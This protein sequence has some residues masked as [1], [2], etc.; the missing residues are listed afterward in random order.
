MLTTLLLS[1]NVSV[2]F[3]AMFWPSLSYNQIFFNQPIRKSG[4]LR[5]GD[6]LVPLTSYH[7]LRI[8]ALIY[9]F[10]FFLG[11]PEDKTKL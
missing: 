3:L 2:L 8:A 4:S 7:I 9:L 5:Q 10:S 11:G 6:A 1:A